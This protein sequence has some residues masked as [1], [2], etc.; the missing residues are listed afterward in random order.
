MKKNDRRKEPNMHNIMQNVLLEELERFDGILVATTNL[1]DNI[2]GAF[3]RRFLYKLRFDPPR[4]TERRLIW[5]SRM[6]ELPLD[7]ASH[8]SS[9]PLSGAQIEN[10]A[11][12]ALL[13]GLMKKHV[14]LAGLEAMA[15]KEGSFRKARTR[16]TGFAPNYV[17]E[18]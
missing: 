9:F 8:L 3:D 14:N 11:R 18:E 17:H 15:A 12:R 2:D 1:I 13:D 6:P 16:I 4:E 10:V 5:M 7:W